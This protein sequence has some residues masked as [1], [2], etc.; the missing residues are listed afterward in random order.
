MFKTTLQKLGQKGYEISVSEFKTRFGFGFNLSLWPS[1]NQPSW[2]A[3]IGFIIIY[4]IIT[5]LELQ[6]IIDHLLEVTIFSHF[7]VIVNKKE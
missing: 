4:M 6:S 3:Q 5:A 1:E 2:G 7:P